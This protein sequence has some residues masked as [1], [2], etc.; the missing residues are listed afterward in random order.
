MMVSGSPA[1]LSRNPT[2][3]EPSGVIHVSAALHGSPSTIVR[4]LGD[5][6]VFLRPR[7]ILLHLSHGTPLIR[8]AA[9]LGEG[10]MLNPEQLRVRRATPTVLAAH[11]SNLQLL[12]HQQRTTN[13]IS[14]NDKVVL[15]AGNQLLFRSCYEHV[16]RGLLSFALGEPTDLRVGDQRHVLRP[17]GW[18]SE[19]WDAQQRRIAAADDSFIHSTGH[20]RSFVRL[21]QNATR[22]GHP[23]STPP[24]WKPRPLAFMPHEGTFYPVW[25]L[26]E[27]MQKLRATSIV[28]DGLRGRPPE[29]NWPCPWPEE[30]LLPTFVWQQYGEL[31]TKGHAK[32]GAVPPI[33]ARMW[34]RGPSQPRTLDEALRLIDTDDPRLRHVCAIKIPHQQILTLAQSHSPVGA[35]RSDSSI[36]FE[37]GGRGSPGTVVGGERQPPRDR[38][39][40]RDRPHRLSYHQRL[41]RW[42]QPWWGRSQPAGGVLHWRLP[43]MARLSSICHGVACASRDIFEFGV[44]G[45]RSLRGI[46]AYLQRASPSVQVR[47]IWGFDSFQGLPRGAQAEA[48]GYGSHT[49]EVAGWIEGAYDA[50]YT[51]R[52]EYRNMSDLEAGI[53]HYINDSRLRFVRGFFSA[54]LTPDLARQMAPAA[55]VD[56]DCDLYSSSRTA[57]EWL[58]SHDLI[59][60]GTIIGYDDWQ[61][62]GHLGEQRAHREMARRYQLRL[63]P[64]PLQQ[65]YE[66]GRSFEVRSVGCRKPPCRCDL[67]CEAAILNPMMY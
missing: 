65:G 2:D 47:T 5:M 14:R 37:S 11:L 16:Q 25:L 24:G 64:L 13:N 21:M 36:H 18:P 35:N 20:H 12:E 45:G 59:V 10:V 66:Y 22:F 27:F 50:S 26:L 32:G 60:P 56:I 43:A 67:F 3:H 57:L 42:S 39:R 34:L 8:S 40:D 62:G 48:T 19:S 54:T 63:T 29:C 38:D 31:L 51:F 28:I 15:L 30:Q 17:I 52:S 55:Y 46:A 58:F 23:W 4:M 9:V 61:S 49:S 6:R 1:A 53:A 33:V 41:K 7:L 44:Y